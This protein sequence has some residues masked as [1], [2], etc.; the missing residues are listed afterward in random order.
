[1]ENLMESFMENH[2]IAKLA[3]AKVRLCLLTD[4]HRN[5]NL[6]PHVSGKYSIRSEGLW[7]RKILVFTRND[8][9]PI[10]SPLS[11]QPFPGEP[12]AGEVCI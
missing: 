10:K 1:M 6:S 8:F 9:G 5:L 12:E 11:S 2:S 7:Y 4:R 3:K